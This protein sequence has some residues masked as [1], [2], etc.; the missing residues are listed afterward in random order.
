MA[1]RRLNAWWRLAIVVTVFWLV[2]STL[3]GAIQYNDAWERSLADVRNGCR[4]QAMNGPVPELRMR[5][6]K[7]DA[8]WTTGMTDSAHRYD[9]WGMALAFAAGSAFLAWGGGLIVLFSTRWIL[10]GRTTR[11]PQAS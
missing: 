11:P 8:N 7:C 6:D 10:A 1:K 2:G 5:L 9:L 3:V 4:D